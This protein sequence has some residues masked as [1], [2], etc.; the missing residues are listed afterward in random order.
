MLVNKFVDKFQSPVVQSRK[1]GTPLYSHAIYYVAGK[2]LP[3][4]N[5]VLVLELELASSQ[6]IQPFF[7]ENMTVLK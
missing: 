3:N 2:C 5:L 7:L 4:I 1:Y 6:L